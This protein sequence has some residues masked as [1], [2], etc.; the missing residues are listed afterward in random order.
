MSNEGM[1]QAPDGKGLKLPRSA[2]PT[3]AAGATPASRSSQAAHKSAHRLA[4]ARM[5]GRPRASAATSPAARARRPWRLRD[6][7]ADH[8]Q[9][10]QLDHEQADKVDQSEDEAKLPEVA[11]ANKAT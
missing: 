5:P 10:G 2:A 6:D 11:L 7:S 3:K 1:R 9:P 4:A 8:P